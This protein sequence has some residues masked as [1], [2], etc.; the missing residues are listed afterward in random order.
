MPVAIAHVPRS[1][2][3]GYSTYAPHNGTISLV[4][5]SLMWWARCNQLGYGKSCMARTLGK[6]PQQ[7][8]MN[9]DRSRRAAP[10]SGVSG[11]QG[12]LGHLPPCTVDPSTRV[13]SVWKMFDIFCSSLSMPK[14]LMRSTRPV[15]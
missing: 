12:T 9:Q 13:T 4:L 5:Q 8:L 6:S 1:V 7:I 14:Q 11:Y 3:K 2:G 10:V 15:L